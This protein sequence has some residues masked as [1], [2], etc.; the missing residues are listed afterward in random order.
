MDSG[1]FGGCKLR[2]THFACY[3]LPAKHPS[4]IAGPLQS[5][6]MHVCPMPI[7]PKPRGATVART[8]MAITSQVLPVLQL[9][10]SGRTHTYGVSYSRTALDSTLK[11]AMSV[12]YI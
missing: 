12:V 2:I 5:V 3:F 6:C 9:I 1:L 8:L 7:A 4:C 11:L 10:R